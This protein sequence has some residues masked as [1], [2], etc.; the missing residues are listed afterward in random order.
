MI[1]AVLTS[2]TPCILF[3]HFQDLAD[4]HATVILCRIPEHNGGLGV[5]GGDAVSNLQA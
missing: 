1:K 3:A 2:Y 4:K 5:K